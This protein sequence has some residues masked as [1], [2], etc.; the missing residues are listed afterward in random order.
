MSRRRALNG[1]LRGFPQSSC[2]LDLPPAGPD[3]FLPL[4]PAQQ[5]V[6]ELVLADEF[7]AAARMRRGDTHPA[8]RAWRER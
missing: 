6:A 7:L 3:G 2:G 8:P 5:E 4:L 1:V